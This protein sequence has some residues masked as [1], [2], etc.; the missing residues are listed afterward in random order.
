MV[1]VYV[2][3]EDRKIRTYYVVN[4][5]SEAVHVE[6]NAYE[7]NKAMISCLTLEII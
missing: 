2:K 5:K 6:F 7:H 4:I 1:D 3:F